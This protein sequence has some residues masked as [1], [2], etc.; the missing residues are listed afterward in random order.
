M[1]A[2]TR[3]TTYHNGI[4]VQDNVQLK[5]LTQYIGIHIKGK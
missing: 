1:I 5:V 3:L 2:L 4:L